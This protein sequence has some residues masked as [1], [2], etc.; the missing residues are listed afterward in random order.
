MASDYYCDDWD[1][2]KPHCDCGGHYSGPR[3]G[4]CGDTGDPDPYGQDEDF[5]RWRW[6]DA[7]R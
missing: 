4:V 3:C 2:E 5:Q 7:G 1:C 6:T